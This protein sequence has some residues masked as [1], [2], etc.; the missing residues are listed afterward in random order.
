MRIT[1]SGRLGKSGGGSWGGEIKGRETTRE[2]GMSAAR[3]DGKTGGSLCNA[4]NAE[5][6]GMQVVRSGGTESGE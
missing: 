4:S 3:D 6:F 1:G 2:F 5:N